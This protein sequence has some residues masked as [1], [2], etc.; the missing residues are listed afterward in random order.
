VHTQVSAFPATYAGLSRELLVGVFRAAPG[1]LRRS[2]SGLDAD[3]LGFRNRPGKWSIQEIVC[4]LADSELVGAVR[5]RQALA[6]APAPRFPAYD[7]D[8]WALALGYGS[9]APAEIGAAVGLFEMLRESAAALL[10][11]VEPSGWE[12]VGVHREWGTL[13]VRQLLELYADHGERHVGQILAIRVAL[14]KPAAMELLL[15]E[16]LYP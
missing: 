14:G 12:R 13:S 1:R 4:H 6:D 9:R 11:R 10:D 7:Q 3:D 2:I 8:R 5:L 15:P 16:R